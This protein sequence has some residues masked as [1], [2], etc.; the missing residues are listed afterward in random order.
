MKPRRPK[1]TPKFR[2]PTWRFRLALSKKVVPSGKVY[3][4]K[5]KHEEKHDE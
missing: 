4:R 1:F 3:R 2:D 5:P